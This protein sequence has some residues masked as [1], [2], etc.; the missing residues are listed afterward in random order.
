[1]TRLDRN[2]QSDVPQ[3]VNNKPKS[4]TDG[5]GA[6]LSQ[7]RLLVALDAML[8]AGSVSGAAAELQ[9]S[10]PAASRLLAQLRAHYADPILI[11]EGRRMVPSPL[12]AK[13]RRRVAALSREARLLLS[14]DRLP[15]A[16]SGLDRADPP[17]ALVPFPEAP[18]LP[19]RVSE[20][21]RA[22]GEPGADTLLRRLDGADDSDC[23]RHRLAAHIARLSGGTGP[24]PSLSASQ[25]RDAFEI[26]LRGEADAVQIGA[27]LAGIQQR[28]VAGPELAGLVAAARAQRPGPGWQGQAP[29]LDWP[30]YPSPRQRRPAWFLAAARLLAD[31]GTP[32][33]LHGFTPQPG[34]VATLLSALQIPQVETLP[35]AEAALDRGGIA[36]LRIETVAPQ[37]AALCNLYAVLGMRTVAQIGLRLLDPLR[38]G[39]TL[40]GVPFSGGG[41]LMTS[42]LTHLGD[43]RLLSVL[44][45]RDVAQATPHRWM[46]LVL[47]GAEGETLTHVPP[48]LTS[49]PEGLPP[50]YGPEAMLTALWQGRERDPGVTAIIRDSAALALMALRPDQPFAT[51]QA[52]ATRLWEDRAGRLA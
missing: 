37:M 31:A 50:G 47:S 14:A 3:S 2:L 40:A 38:F 32:I 48:S 25:A 41:G 16:E 30:V 1:M 44:S 27:L 23:P 21:T 52:E 35:E 10:V 33:L 11:R 22:E 17:S 20:P 7:L 5:G 42:A 15:Q 51:H 6:T 34:P 28:G 9:M 26:V 39:V 19:L 13:L 8:R 4:R 43:G 45:Q 49:A 29:G 12:V 24:A 18:R 46:T 36:F